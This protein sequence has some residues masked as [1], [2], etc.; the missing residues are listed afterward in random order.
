MT[1]LANITADDLRQVLA[2][3]EGKTPTQRVLAGISYK[4]G[5]AQ[6]T[7]AERYGVHRNT[8][9]NWLER[10]ERLADEPFEEVVYDAHRSGREAELTAEQQKQ[11][12][13]TLLQPPTEAG[14]DAPAWTPAL[15][16]QYITNAF[17]VEYHVRHIRRLMTKAGL[18]YKTARPEYQN[19]D[20]RA[21]E[22]FKEGFQK[23]WMS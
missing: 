6:T 21:Q 7:I 10:L 17:A 19:A 22:A 11:L 2:E 23:S 15:V 16:Q 18:S 4:D 5:V 13:E 20:E 14:V 9:R 3:V 12:E 1:Y 8:V